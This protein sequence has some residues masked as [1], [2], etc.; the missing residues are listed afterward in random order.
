MG[1]CPLQN[2]KNNHTM[3]LT[4]KEKWMKFWGFG[5][6][7]NQAT[8]EIH[9]LEEKHTNCRLDLMR[10]KKYVTWRRALRL[11]LKKGYNGCRYCFP[12]FDKG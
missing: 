11:I 7:V 8:K 1:G 3:E 12:A 5:Y 2:N 9:K 10:H 6:V 4:R